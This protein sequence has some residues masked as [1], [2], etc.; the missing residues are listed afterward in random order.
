MKVKVVKFY[1]DKYTKT[2]H[3]P[4]EAAGGDSAKQAMQ[5]IECII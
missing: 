3:K 1:R 2:I 5:D 4:N